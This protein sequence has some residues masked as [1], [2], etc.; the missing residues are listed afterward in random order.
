MKES[1]LNSTWNSLFED[2]DII[3]QISVYGKYEIK[4]KTIKKYREPRLVTKFDS[5]EQMPIV[6]RQNNL[7]IFPVSRDAYFN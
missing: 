1:L 5:F 2:F 7:G 4:A 6:F 3:K